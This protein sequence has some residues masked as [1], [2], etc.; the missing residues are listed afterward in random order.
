[1]AQRAQAFAQARRLGGF[2]GA[3]AAFESEEFSAGHGPHIGR[4]AP[5]RKG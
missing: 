3:F 4:F 2:A 5:A 1:M